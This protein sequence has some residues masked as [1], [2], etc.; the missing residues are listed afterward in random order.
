MQCSLTLSL[1]LLERGADVQRRGFQTQTGEKDQ[2][3]VVVLQ[4]L[5][6]R[7]EQGNFAA[8]N[9]AATAAATADDDVGQTAEC[10]VC[11]TLPTR[12]SGDP[13]AV[14]SAQC[15]FSGTVSSSNS[16]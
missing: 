6:Q 11:S 14:C 15:S 12:R 13:V 16:S 5:L 9:A 1:T 3:S 10:V 4:Q 2:Q 8:V 7:S